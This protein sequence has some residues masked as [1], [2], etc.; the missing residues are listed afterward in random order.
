[1]DDVEM[2]F[3]TQ[4]ND[5]DENKDNHEIMNLGGEN[6]SKGVQKG[7]QK[8][9]K[10]SGQKGQKPDKGAKK[11]GDFDFTFDEEDEWAVLKVDCV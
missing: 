3:Y 1:M 6:S 8:G 2:L 4:D 5:N 7:G 10:K 11:T 9:G